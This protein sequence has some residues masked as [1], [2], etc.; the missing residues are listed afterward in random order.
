MRQTVPESRIFPIQVVGS[1]KFGQFS[2][3]N[4]EKTYNMYITDDWFVPFPGYRKVAELLS[5]GEGRGLFRSFR[6]NIMIAVVNANVYRINNTLSAQLIGSL[7]TASGDVYIDENLNG[8]ICLVDGLNAYIYNHTLAPNLTKQT[9]PPDLVPGYV[10]YHNTFFLFGNANTTNL[11]KDWYVFEPHPTD[12]SLL[13]QVAA[14]PFQVKPDYPLAVI[15]IPSQANNVLVMGGSACE[16]RTQIGGLETYSRNRTINVDYGV[17]SVSTIAE[18][19]DMI[20]W[21]GVNEDNQASLMIFKGQQVTSIS[22][23]GI[24]KFLDN[25]VHPEQS[26]ADFAKINGHLQYIITFY[27]QEDNTTLMYDTKTNMFFHLSDRNTNY[28]EMRNAVFFNNT[29]YFVSINNGSLY[30]LSSRYFDINY[31]I[32]DGVLWDDPQLVWEIPRVRICDTFRLPENAPYRVNSFTFTMDMG[33]DDLPAVH[34]C[35]T[36][37]ITEDA[38]PIHTQDNYQ[39]IPEDAGPEDCEAHEYQGRVDLCLSNNGG[40]TFGNYVP[41]HLNPKGERRNIIRWDSQGIFNEYTPKLKFWTRGRVVAGP[42]FIE[43][44]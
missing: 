14:I 20:M 31:N 43:V 22:T 32:F 42:A 26:T 10:T 37:I 38:I 29:L 30:E 40:E 21:L 24:D 28:H 16:I 23:D 39:V 36:I 35:L 5:S 7:D 27:S 41:R 11:S 1:S 12:Q 2:K 25:L 3:I 8:Q 17:L 4:A 34:D 6:A 44:F 13:Q 33:N 18:S 15:P 19:E 9:V